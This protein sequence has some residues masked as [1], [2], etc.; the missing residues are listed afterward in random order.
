MGGQDCKTPEDSQINKLTKLSQSAINNLKQAR[1][2]ADENDDISDEKK[3]AMANYLLETMSE[4]SFL[5]NFYNY[6][7]DG[8][9]LRDSNDEPLGAVMTMSISPSG[10]TKN[11][12]HLNSILSNASLSLVLSDLSQI[13]RE[14][15]QRKADQNKKHGKAD[16]EKWERESMD[17]IMYELDKLYRAEENKK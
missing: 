11:Y 16:Y 4:S 15:E 13:K 10:K 14:Q 17:E 3:I 8:I 1:I 9:A 12:L 5:E 6:A 7:F 2:N